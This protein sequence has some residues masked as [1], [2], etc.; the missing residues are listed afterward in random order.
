MYRT[1]LF[2]HQDLGRNEVVETLPI[3]QRL[4]FDQHQGRLWVVC[5]RCE[6]WNLTPF[7]DRWEAIEACEKA[8]R[9]TRRRF[10]TDQIGIARLA[11]GLELVRIGQPLRPEFA[12]WRYGDQFG[13]RRRKYLA[14]GAL[15]AAAS[16]AMIIT[17]WAPPLVGLGLQ[18]AHTCHSLY[19]NRRRI[20]TVES[21]PGTVTPLT[22]SQIYSARIERESTVDHPVLRFRATVRGLF[23]Q[24]DGEWIRIEGKPAL[25][26]AATLL[27][28][29]NAGAGKPGTVSAA[30]ARLDRLSEAE[31]MFG[32]L[33]AQSGAR[34]FTHELHSLDADLRLA[35]EMAAHEESERAWL[36]GELRS[37]EAEWQRAEEIA[38]IAD[39][40]TAEALS[41]QL[42]TLKSR[43]P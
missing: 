24:A 9:A 33:A 26:A 27:T 15:G 13:R 22:R 10:S 8:Y 19:T 2:C 31:G 40:L 37:L 16:A 3:G 34:M 42:E 25:R 38:G 17:P 4:A 28:V 39:S 23:A 12:A 35:L 36:A 6:R 11:E 29:I 14:Y 20:A 21:E 41:V 32:Q 1:C 5:R 7:D 43:R 18:L 30:G